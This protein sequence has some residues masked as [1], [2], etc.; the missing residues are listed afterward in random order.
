MNMKKPKYFEFWGAKEPV[1][2]RDRAPGEVFWFAENRKIFDEVIHWSSVPGRIVALK[3]PSGYGKTSMVREIYHGFPSDWNASVFIVTGWETDPLWL[4]GGIARYFGG[5]PN[6]EDPDL[7]VKVVQNGVEQL[8]EEGRHLL[9][10]L[11]G[12]E[13]LERVDDL[14]VLKDI[15]EMCGGCISILMAGQKILFEHCDKICDLEPWPI[16]VVEDYLKWSLKEAGLSNISLSKEMLETIM[17]RSKGVPGSIA[18]LAE[19]ALVTGAMVNAKEWGPDLIP[20]DSEVNSGK[21]DKKRRPRKPVAL[22]LG[23][24]KD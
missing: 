22:A 3:G 23:N 4:M 14:A 16:S 15:Q 21:N 18:R 17:Y 7:Q 19:G 12:V 6:W 24:K 13:R 2:I 10:L 1:F 5:D 20:G 11:D 8:Q 9:L